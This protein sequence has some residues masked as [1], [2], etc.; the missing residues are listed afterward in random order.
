MNFTPQK[1]EVPTPV[2]EYQPG[3]VAPLDDLLAGD[4]PRPSPLKA[5]GPHGLPVLIAYATIDCAMVVLVG[6][7]VFYLESGIAR[8]WGTASRITEQLTLGTYFA[9]IF[10]YAVLNV[11]SCASQD[12]Y[13]TPRDRG[14]LEEILMVSQAVSLATAV[15]VLFVFAFGVQGITRISVLALAIFTG[16]TL[17]GWRYLKRRMILN[18]TLQGIGVSRVLIVGAGRTGRALA[19]SLGANPS[20]GYEVCGFLEAQSSSDPLILGRLGELGRVVTERFIDEIFLTPPIDRE[21]VK[22]FVL[23]ARQLRLG[24]KVVPDLYDGIGWRAPVHAVG[25]FPVMQ[26]NENPIPGFGVAV[27]RILDVV[28]AASGLVL[29]APFLVLLAAIIRL[30]SPGRAFYPAVRVGYKARRFC[31]WKLRTMYVGADS[32]K[33]ALRE[34]HE[35]TGPWFKMKNDPR[36]TRAGRWLRKFSLDELPQLWNVVRGEM[37]LVGPRPHPVD[38]FNR[39]KPEHLRRLDVKPGLTGLWQVTARRDPYFETNLALDLD[40]IENWSL[41]LDLEILFRSVGELFRGS[42]E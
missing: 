33:E 15:L 8:S 30:D 29:T 1:T 36:V 27:K 24:L 28:I 9:L 23:V 26:L 20:L 42:G 2:I 41:R 13:R 31:C 6:A 12:L 40:Y 17:S 38:D 11:L 37:S 39:Y 21:V 34:T 3:Q 5:S 22:Q 10:A 4:P 19:A 25:G 14:V 7:L 32:D 18:R 35:R 16:A